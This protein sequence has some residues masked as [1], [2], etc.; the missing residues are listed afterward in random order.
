MH[1][2]T[3]NQEVVDRSELVIIAVL[4]EDRHE[5]LAGLR[6]A[7]DKVLVNVMAGVGNDDPRGTHP[8]SAKSPRP[9]CASPGPHH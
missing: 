1:V 8:T 2:C 5:A 3:D 7:G 4:R 6:V 9:T